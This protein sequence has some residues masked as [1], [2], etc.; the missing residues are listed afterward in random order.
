MQ[1]AVQDNGKGTDHAS[2]ESVLQADIASMAAKG[3]AMDMSSMECRGLE[4]VRMQMDGVARLAKA[5]ECKLEANAQ[6]QSKAWQQALSGYAAGIFFCQ[7]GAPRCPRVVASSAD[8]AAFAELPSA[9]GA[10]A[11]VSG[12]TEPELS[13]ED[14]AARDNLRATLHLN[15]AAAALKLSRW[16]I[17]RTAC[18]FVLMVQ[19]NAAP[20][21]ARYRLALALEGEGQLTEA[22]AALE[23]L[24]ALFPD[25]DDAAKLLASL[26]K[27]APAPAVDYETMDAEAWGKLSEE[28][29][30]RALEEINKK[31]DA[32][33]GEKDDWDTDQLKEVL[34]GKKNKEEDVDQLR[35]VLG[36]GKK[37]T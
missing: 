23:K 18:Q 4:A 31:L 11:P 13:K 6:F 19:A 28:E 10:G 8:E 22:C 5:E 21:K 7:R 9:L 12:S 35:E 33:M 34:S 17:A 24:L 30:Q 15:L 32:E 26:K 36:A 16:T 14:M 20:A 1:W 37:K 25:N 3:G 2:L 27:R 29:Q